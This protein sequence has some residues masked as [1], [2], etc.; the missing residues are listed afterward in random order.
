MSGRTSPQQTRR[1]TV[2]RRP[3]SVRPSTGVT[4]IDLRPNT[5]HCTWST[6][7]GSPSGNSASA[8]P[9]DQ[10]NSVLERWTYGT[11]W[12]CAMAHHYSDR[13]LAWAWGASTS[14]LHQMWSKAFEIRHIFIWDDMAFFSDTCTLKWITKKIEHIMDYENITLPSSNRKVNQIGIMFRRFP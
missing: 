3:L 9:L 13:F 7:T 12:Y 10:F 11:D 4:A 2:P 1:R 14:G 8:T 6:D 5:D